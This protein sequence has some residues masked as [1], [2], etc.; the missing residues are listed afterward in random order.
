MNGYELA[1]LCSQKSDF[2]RCKT[3]CVAIYHGH[4]L[5][6]GFNS[7]K[8]SPLQA[9]YNQRRGFDGYSYKSSLHAEMMVISKIRNLDIDFGQVKLYIWRGTD[10][11]MYSRP[12]EACE[13]AIR[14][15]GIK[16]VFYTGNNSYIK[17]IYR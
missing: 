4:I 16:K 7:N 3:G 12:C 2:D 6:K 13:A 8:T 17:E 9:Y 11:P 14:D 1:R 5:A 15:V 10:Y